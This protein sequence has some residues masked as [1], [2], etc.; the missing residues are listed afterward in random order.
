ME[1]VWGSRG[2]VWGNGA[3][4]WRA[5]LAYGRPPACMWNGN[6]AKAGNMKAG[7]GMRTLRIFGNI[8]GGSR[9]WGMSSP[10]EA[11][12]ESA[13]AG[14]RDTRGSCRRAPR[15]VAP[16]RCVQ[17]DATTGNCR[18]AFMPHPRMALPRR[19]AHALGSPTGRRSGPG[20]RRSRGRGRGWPACRSSPVRTRGTSLSWLRPS[21][22]CR[23][24]ASYYPPL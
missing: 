15:R 23:E 7:C 12:P 9:A 2:S 4:I 1:V 13:A 21:T 20:G 6:P 19:A 16:C 22:R 8:G 5:P 17:K 11:T 10:A 18:D 24:T 3:G 14:S